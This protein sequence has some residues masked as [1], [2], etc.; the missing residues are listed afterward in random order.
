MGGKNASSELG[1]GIE[2]RQSTNYRSICFSLRTAPLVLLPERILIFSTYTHTHTRK[3]K[4]RGQLREKVS[5]T[6]R[7]LRHT[8]Q[9]SR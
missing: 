7:H 9:S 4:G 3:N 8:A 2:A 6:I 1:L 5:K